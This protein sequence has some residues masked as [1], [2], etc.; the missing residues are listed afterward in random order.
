MTLPIPGFDHLPLGSVADRIRALDEDQL[1]ELIDHEEGQG[2]RLPV[3]EVLRSRREQLRDGAR[4]SD[5]A[6][7]DLHPETGRTEHGSPVGPD[8]A[9]RPGPPDRHGL[10]QVTWGG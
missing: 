6:Q 9:A 10:R 2:N 3:L 8:S 4:P 5:G 7:D 1:Q